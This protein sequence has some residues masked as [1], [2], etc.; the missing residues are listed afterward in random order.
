MEK[1]SKGYGGGRDDRK[2]REEYEKGG[3]GE[4][5]GSRGELEENGA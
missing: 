4:G 3:M 5:R 1:G 2:W